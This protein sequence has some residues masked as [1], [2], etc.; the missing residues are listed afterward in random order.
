MSADNGV[1]ILKT[2]ARPIKNGGSYTNQHGKFEYRVDYCSAIDN[3][4]YSD[5][6]VPA[7]FGNSK[8]FDSLED[9]QAEATII[10]D[11]HR[12]LEYGICQVEHK[13]VFPNMTV[14]QANQALDSYV[15]DYTSLIDTALKNEWQ[16]VNHTLHNTILSMP[17]DHPSKNYAMIFITVKYN[18]KEIIIPKE[19]Y[20]LLTQ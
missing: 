6:C 8:V 20:K 16:L 3:I 10:A 14:E 19:L 18:N 13:R 9:A 5:L 4:Y 12:Y 17:K 15:I 11:K 7:M 1:Y 2:P